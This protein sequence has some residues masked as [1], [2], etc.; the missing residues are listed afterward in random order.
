MVLVFAETSW[1]ASY[2]YN[3]WDLNNTQ[4][5][6]DTIRVGFRDKWSDN[7]E[8]SASYTWNDFEGFDNENGFQ[9]GLAYKISS[10]FDLVAD[11]E[12]ISGD[13]NL[14]TVSFGIRLNF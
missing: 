4:F 13:F 12:T 5:D 8:F 11:Y 1:F 2:T 3:T 7:F 9:V 14:D 6:V 10:S